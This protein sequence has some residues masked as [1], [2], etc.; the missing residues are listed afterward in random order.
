MNVNRVAISSKGLSVLEEE[1]V[2]FCPFAQF[3]Y[4]K[5]LSHSQSVVVL[6]DP[7]FFW[8]LKCLFII[9]WHHVCTHVIGHSLIT[10]L[11]L[12]TR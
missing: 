8:S 10:G 12:T 9:H 6:E 2:T 5:Q 4:L 11:P 1:D 7:F 3:R